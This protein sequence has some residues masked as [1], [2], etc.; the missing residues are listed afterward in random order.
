MMDLV[1]E[2]MKTVAM[3]VC[4]TLQI[5]YQGTGHRP[6][7]LGAD[8]HDRGRQEVF[9]RGL[10]RHLLTDEEAIAAA[11]AHKVELPEIPPRGP[12]WPSSSTR[13]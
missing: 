5:T 10:C 9:R 4:G 2:M 8:D 3:K 6:E 1:E 11:K 12:S 13:L 7:P